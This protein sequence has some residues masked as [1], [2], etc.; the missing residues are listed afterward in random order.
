MNHVYKPRGVYKQILEDR[1]GQIL[2]A[3]PAGTGKSRAILEKIH[4]MCLLNPGMKALI[5]RKTQKSLSASALATLEKDVIAEAI[6]DGTVRWYGGSGSKPAGYIYSNGA[7][8]ATGGMDDPVKIMSTEYDYIYAQEAVQLTEE[9]WE[10]LASRLRNGVISFQQLIGDTN[11]EAPTHWLKQRCELGLTKLYETRHV[12]NPRF[13]NE[14]GSATEEG[15]AYVIDVLSKLTGLRYLRLYEGRWAGAEGIIYDGFDSTIHI[16]DPFDIPS[17]WDRFWSLDFGVTNP[18]V[19]QHWAEDP[20]GRLYLYR[21][22]Y[23]TGKTAD[24][25][26]R[27][28]LDYVTDEEGE[29]TEPEPWAIVADHDGQGR[30]L[31][32]RVIGISTKAAQ[33]RVSEGIQMVQERLRLAIDGKPRLFIFNNALVMRDQSLVNRKQPTCTADEFVRYIWDVK[34]DQP[35]KEFDHGMDAMRY[36]VAYRDLNTSTFRMD[37]A[38]GR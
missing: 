37:F 5:V 8:I 20:D 21:E 10:S 2:V 31:F 32:E 26:A 12:D 7:T 30:P 13:F 14:D 23:L 29:W 1:S 19:V 6:T 34:K 27:I 22:F 18:T 24:E 25:H 35:V 3:G 36:L 16:I 9:D 17:D 33:K 28:V 11:P 15:K 38:N 4:F